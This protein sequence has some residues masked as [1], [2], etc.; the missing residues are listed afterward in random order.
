MTKRLRRNQSGAVLRALEKAGGESSHADLAAAADLPNIK[1]Y[2]T[3]QRLLRREFIERIEGGFR[4]TDAGDEYIETHLTGEG[5]PP[6]ARA[7]EGRMRN[8]LRCGREFFSTWHGNRICARCNSEGEW[9]QPE[10]RV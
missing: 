7:H 4:I 1:F 6:F 5:K 10:E 9:Y 3:L 8:C 2:Q